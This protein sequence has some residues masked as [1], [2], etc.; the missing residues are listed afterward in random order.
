VDAVGMVWPRDMISQTGVVGRRDDAHHFDS[1]LPTKLSCAWRTDV[2][3]SARLLHRLNPLSDK[4]AAAA[5]KS[6]G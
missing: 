6:A 5:N 1:S 3:C 4:S 2:D